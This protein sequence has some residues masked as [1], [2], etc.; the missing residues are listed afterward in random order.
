MLEALFLATVKATPATAAAASAGEDWKWM[1]PVAT[2][3]LGFVLKWLQDNVT[4]KGRRRHEKDLRREQR[5]DLLRMRRLEAERANMLALQPMVTNLL[6]KCSQCHLERVRAVSSLASIG[7]KNARLPPE[8]DEE[9]RKALADLVPLRARLHS[10]DVTSLIDDV[11][12]DVVKTQSP[13][14]GQEDADALWFGLSDK[15]DQLQALIGDRIKSLE[16]ENQQLGDP[17]GQ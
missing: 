6:R 7:W 10:T 3:I 8:L 14:I 9:L 4:E 15:H 1:V 16:D 2:L 5:Y 11:V 12:S 13:R 17:P